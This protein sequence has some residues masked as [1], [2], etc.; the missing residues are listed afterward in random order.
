MGFLAWPRATAA[1]GPQRPEPDDFDPPTFPEPEPPILVV[2]TDEIPG[3]E[4]DVVLGTVL[5]VTPRTHNTYSEGVKRLDGQ[6][7]PGLQVIMAYW[8]QK[9]ITQMAQAAQNRGATAVVA[10]RFDNREVSEMWCEIT[11]YGTAVIAHRICPP[12]RGVAQVPQPPQDA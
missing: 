7:N 9:A 1:V 4:I 8:R 12:D 11:A 10:M 5:G 3:F 2:T 6:M